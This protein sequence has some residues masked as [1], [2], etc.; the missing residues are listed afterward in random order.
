MQQKL[1]M[2]IIGAVACLWLASAQAAAPNPQFL[3]T[4]EVD[5]SKTQPQ[6]PPGG[7][8]KMTPK[9][10]TVTIKDVGGGKWAN[11]IVVEMADGTKQ[12]PP[13]M[14]V[15]ID[16]TPVPITGNPMADSLVVTSPDPNT[17][18]VTVLK[19]GKVV[20][21]QTSRLSADGKQLVY[22]T[23][24]TGPDGKP[25]HMTQVLNKK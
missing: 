7:D 1:L 19:D 22:T 2:T 20:S 13:S 18:T 9:S 15:S 16:G 10:V 3:G 6:P 12:T 4:W 5:L 24:A 21:T 17:T 23:D 14:P 25:F 8:P 11:E